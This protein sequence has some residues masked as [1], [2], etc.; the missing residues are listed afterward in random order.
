MEV[1]TEL[2]QVIA[3]ALTYAYTLG[4]IEGTNSCVHNFDVLAAGLLKDTGLCDYVRG[5]LEQKTQEALKGL[6]NCRGVHIELGKNVTFSVNASGL[7]PDTR[8][9]GVQVEPEFEENR[10]FYENG[11]FQLRETV[12]HAY[13]TPL[14]QN[15]AV[16]W[17]AGF[18]P[19]LCARD[20]QSVSVSQKRRLLEDP[21]PPKKSVKVS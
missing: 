10:V 12:S 9:I 21:G 5:P 2:E 15:E 18:A 17:G 20:S 8:S 3:E 7:I 16:Q 4:I 14:T 11:R 6:S 19:T 1:Y 13:P